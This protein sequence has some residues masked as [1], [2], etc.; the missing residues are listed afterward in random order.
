ML[1]FQQTLR[2]HEHVIESLCYGKK[3]TDAIAV[4]MSPTKSSGDVA[5][6]LLFIY[7]ISI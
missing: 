3:P 7:F 2:G 6:C 1:V 4:A 5:V